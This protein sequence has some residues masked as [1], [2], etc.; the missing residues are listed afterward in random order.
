MAL[1]DLAHAAVLTQPSFRRAGAPRAPGRAT[2]DDSR[3]RPRGV[4]GWCAD[5]PG[6]PTNI[7][8]KT[9]TVPSGEY[10]RY[11]S[12]TRIDFMHENICIQNIQLYV[13]EYISTSYL[14]YRILLVVQESDPTLS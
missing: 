2:R 9:H 12:G 10:C 3:D 14:R 1:W 4:L 8:Q 13:F 7:V 5:P 11:G 6:N